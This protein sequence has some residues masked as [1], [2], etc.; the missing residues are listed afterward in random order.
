MERVV[1]RVSVGR[2]IGLAVGLS[3]IAGG[4]LLARQDPP[5]QQP[6]APQAAP[7]A[8]SLKLANS[9]HLIIWGVKPAKAADFEALWSGIMAQIAKSERP[10]VKEFGATFTN[11]YKLNA[12]TPEAV[13]YVF[14]IEKPSQT[15]SYNPGK[16]IYEFLYYQTPEGKEAGIPR[17]EADELFKKIGTMQ[18]MFASIN[19]W[20]LTKIGT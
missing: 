4:T 6:A 13:M 10:E 14:Q 2:A 12:S 19:T 18:D 17:T 20:P 11:M 1:S 7:Q 5:A 15:Q 9:P 3:V 16:I 8:D